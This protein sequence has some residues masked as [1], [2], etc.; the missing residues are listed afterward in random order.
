MRRFLDFGY[1]FA[2]NDRCGGSLI[3]CAINRNS[4]HQAYAKNLPGYDPGRFQAVKKEF[5]DSL[6]EVK[7][8]P[9]T[10]KPNA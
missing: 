10:S 2:R 6:A 1:A 9:K 7:G 3:K 4:P 8:A 5:F